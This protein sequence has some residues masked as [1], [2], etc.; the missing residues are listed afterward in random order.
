MPRKARMYLPDIPCHVIQRGN[1]RE[2][3]FFSDQNYQFYLVCLYD[4]CRKYSVL[5]HAY[6]LKTIRVHQLITPFKRHGEIYG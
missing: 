5:V 4:V 3:S 6:A 1:N 2:T